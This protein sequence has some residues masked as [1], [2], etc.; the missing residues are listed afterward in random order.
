MTNRVSVTCQKDDCSVEFLCP[1]YLVLERKYCAMCS[2]ARCIDCGKRG[3]GFNSY[4]FN[5]YYCGTPTCGKCAK[6][7]YVK[8][9]HGEEG[10]QTTLVTMCLRCHKGHYP[11]QYGGKMMTV[12]QYAKSSNEFFNSA[13]LAEKKDWYLLALAQEELRRAYNVMTN[14]VER[15]E[16]FR[17]ADVLTDSRKKFNEAMLGLPVLVERRGGHALVFVWSAPQD[18]TCHLFESMG[19]YLWFDEMDGL[20]TGPTCKTKRDAIEFLDDYLR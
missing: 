8:M 12:A 14:H 9:H 20:P 2:N 16:K 17:C 1:D 4:V 6:Q 5:C 10:L 3:D 15:V 18:R 13:T 11:R 7:E 19:R